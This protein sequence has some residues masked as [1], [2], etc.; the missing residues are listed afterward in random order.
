[1]YALSHHNEGAPAICEWPAT[2]VPHFSSTVISFASG[3]E[4]VD[5]GD[6][7]RNAR[8]IPIGGAP[9]P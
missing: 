7:T 1:M 4:V 8:Q 9:R 3:E 2:R 6:S 5:S